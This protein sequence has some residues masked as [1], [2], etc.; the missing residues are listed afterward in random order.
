MLRFGSRDKFPKLT[1][2]LFKYP[3]K[4][5]PPVV[6]SLLERF[7]RLGDYVFDP[8]CGSGTTLVECA[9]AGRN[10]LGGDVDPL[11]VFV[12]RCKTHFYNLPHLRATTCRMVEE[13]EKMRRSPREYEELK[14][15]DVEASLIHEVCAREGLWV[16]KIPNLHHWFR[17]YVIVDLA[18]ILAYIERSEVPNTHRMFFKLCFAAIIRNAS[19]ADPVPVSGLEV[20]SHMRRK[21]AA[22]RLVDPFAL[23]F[24]AVKARIDATAEFQEHAAHRVK[25]ASYQM[26]ATRAALKVRRKFDLVLTSPPY[27][28]AVDYYRRHT[29]ETYWLR[30]AADQA[31]RI[32]F[33]NRYIGRSQVS[34]R[35]VLVRSGYIRGERAR[36]WHAMMKGESPQHA[37]SFKHYIV[38]M[39]ASLDQM[40]E[41]THREGRVVLVVGNSSWQGVELPTAELLEEASCAG[42]D[43]V[44]EFWYPIANRYMSYQRRNGADIAREF[45]LVLQPR[46]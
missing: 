38:S 3:A 25:I 17:N 5:H 44:E 37:D 15:T 46:S 45:V 28:N 1:H 6:T 18:R 29:L 30:F 21:D 2:Y 9:V 20:T 39:Q 35:D 43:K 13:L 42:F 7:S 40:R 22:G 14:F 33:R 24:K 41:V 32:T 26:D 16:P 23:F 12:A 36:E 27:H 19:N 8:F 31:E 10:A 34:A 4:F 11:A